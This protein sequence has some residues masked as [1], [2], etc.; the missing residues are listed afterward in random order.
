MAAR[1][2]LRRGQAEALKT[3]LLEGLVL[4]GLASTVSLSA[5]SGKNGKD[6]PSNPKKQSPPK[7]VEKPKEKGKLLTTHPAAPVPPG[8]SPS[9]SS[10]AA[11]NRGRAVAGTHPGGRGSKLPTE[12]GLLKALARK[13]LVAF[14]QKVPSPLGVQGLGA[15]AHGGARKE[16]DDSSSSS[17]SSSSPSSDS[18]SDEEWDVPKARPRV[19]SRG[20]GGSLTP[21]DTRPSENRAPGV[22]VSAKEQ[23]RVQKP[24]TDVTYPER[25]SQPKKKRN[26]PMPLE[27]REEAVPEFMTPRSQAEGEAL[28]QKAKVERWQKTHRPKE[29]E[30]GSQKPLGVGGIS[31]DRTEARISTQLRGRLVPTPNTQEASCP[32]AQVPEPDGKLALPWVQEE[33]TGKP[34]GGGHSEAKGILEDQGS[35]RSS[36]PVA[37]QEEVAQTTGLKP[38]EG[39]APPLEAPGDT[40]E[41]A[42]AHAAAEPFDNTTYRNLQHHDY[43]AYTFL[44]LNLDLSRF[45]L[46]QPSSGRESPRH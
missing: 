19:G 34:A 25:A 23:S 5:Q 16:T 43:N 44:D 2:V 38:E 4:R 24:H 28:K 18:E 14:P 31:P 46:P 40:Q 17:S 33:K 39:P 41:S 45:R 32:G 6:L 15:E 7:N 9:A 37:V 10:P 30:K 26:P 3:V 22:T 1:F 20:Q 11:G 42:P 12:E 35:V 29:M 13:T 36:K 27:S 21:E 8:L